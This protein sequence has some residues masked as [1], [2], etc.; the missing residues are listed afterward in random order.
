MQLLYALCSE[1]RIIYKHKYILIVH[2]STSQ[3]YL[4]LFVMLVSVSMVGKPYKK[5]QRGR[6]RHR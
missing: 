2:V 4:C 6:P 5:S 1:I 3:E